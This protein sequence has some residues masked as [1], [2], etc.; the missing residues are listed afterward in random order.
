MQNTNIRNT[1]RNIIWGIV[2][3][4]FAILLPFIMRTVL[5]YT[6]GTEYLGLDSLFTS[7]LQM[8]NIAELG[9]GSAVVFSM[10]KPIVEKD[11]EKICTLLNLYRSAYRLIG[12]FILA[13]GLLLAPLLP[14]LIKG[15]IPSDVN[16]Y[17]LY[18]I[19]LGNTVIGYWMFSYK[20]SL[21]SAHQREDVN[22][23]ANTVITL[24]KSG[25]QIALVVMF[26]N[27][28]LYLLL[29]PVATAAEN[30]YVAWLTQKRFPQYV[31]RGHLDHN[32]R[33][34]ISRR[35]GGLMIQNVCQVSRNSF[36]SI[37]ISAYLGLAQVT[38]Y[39]NYYTIMYGVHTLLGCI[40]KAMTASVGNQIV[41]SDTEKNHTD[42]M[43]FT[44]MYMWLAGVATPCLLTLFQPFMKLWMG[45]SRMLPMSSVTLLCIYFYALCMGDIRTVYVTG[46]GLWWEG[47]YRS[48]LE[49]LSN[50]V[51]NIV[52]G[53]HMGI[54][55]II[56]A[57]IL[58]LLVINFGY[59]ATIIYRY[60]FKNGKLYQFYR[61][62]CFYAVVT[63]V[64]VLIVYAICRQIP[65]GGI[66]R[67]IGKG[68]AAF[69]L[70]SLFLL[71][72]YHRTENFR[73]ALRFIRKIVRRN[74]SEKSG[75]AIW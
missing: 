42:M 62:H 5:I 45:K 64:T 29:M 9:F 32:S 53:K 17:L 69:S 7:V 75:K 44:F 46:D 14:G 11:T 36:D 15:N 19:F 22:L 66:G 52:L 55:G 74:N 4:C 48:V 1:T 67:I 56:L 60:Y 26:H 24:C 39:G 63:T 43:R 54:S 68:A 59:G 16:L 37:I 23:N 47:R 10:Y 6:L 49:A 2:N 41:V 61:Q 30:L 25:L 72:A 65:D 3:R 40:A 21:F 18:F 34:D 58:S 8:L 50:I 27:Y 20:K 38:I 13:A 28:Y 33:R 73:D 57:T 12:M 51:L 35:I 31:C 70:S 71:L